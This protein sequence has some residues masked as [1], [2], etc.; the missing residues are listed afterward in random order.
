MYS[1][2]RRIRIS[3]QRM[4]S[5]FK[6]S[7]DLFLKKRLERTMDEKVKKAMK[8]LIRAGEKIASWVYSMPCSDGSGVHKMSE[9]IERAK[10]LIAEK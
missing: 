1:G 4:T 2:F 3:G 8:D 9:A 6:G 10:K 7:H 5:G